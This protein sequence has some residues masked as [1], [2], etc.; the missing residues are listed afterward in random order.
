MIVVDANILAFH[1]IQGERT[2]DTLA[3]KQADPEWIVPP[4]WHVEFQSVLWKYVRMGGMPEATALGLLDKAMGM[5][6]ANEISPAP[7][8]VLR[9]GLKWG[10]SVYDAQ[11]VS[12]ARQLA[13]PC[14]TEDAPLTKACP[15]IA[16]SIQAYVDQ[17]SSQGR[18][19]VRESHAVYQAVSRPAA[20][21]RAGR[22][23]R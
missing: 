14:I 6:S 4:F 7:E 16:L 19:M 11:Y 18:S 15:G 2:R 22:K 9:D 5:F 23:R 20:R 13:V 3:L 1:L 8:A 12:L 21:A 17:S 10:I